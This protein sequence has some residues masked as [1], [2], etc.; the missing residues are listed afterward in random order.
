[1]AQLRRSHFPREP[2][3]AAILHCPRRRTPRLTPQPRSLATSMP[4]PA[5]CSTWISGKRVRV[6]ARDGVAQLYWHHGRTRLPGLPAGRR[7]RRPD[8]HRP[9]RR[10]PRTLSAVEP[11]IGTCNFYAPSHRRRQ[12][13]HGPRL[14]TASHSAAIRP[15]S[16]LAD[17]R[18]TTHRAASPS[19]RSASSSATCSRCARST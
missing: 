5:A 18:I 14:S 10:P 12:H 13:Q 7:R 16:L 2:L 17:W 8:P 1:M 15:A 3:A 6:E 11:G 9:L 4:D 19:T